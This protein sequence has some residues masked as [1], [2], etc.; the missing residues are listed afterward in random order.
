MKNTFLKTIGGA[1][2]AILMMAMFAQVQVSAQDI[3]D[4]AQSNEQTQEDLST[5]RENTRKLEG[6]WNLQVTPR[7]CQTGVPGSTVAV[8]QTFMRGGT[9]IDFGGVLSPSLRTPGQGVWSYQSRR[10]YSIAF[11]FFRFNAD[12]TPAGRQIQRGQIEMSRDGNSYTATG[13]GQILDAG[14][15]VIANT[16]GTSTATRFQ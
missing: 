9:M 2:L 12:G 15:N 1:A 16:C 13:M 14:G 11:Q 7:N 10:Q 4:E 6:S 5:R 8:M 3:I